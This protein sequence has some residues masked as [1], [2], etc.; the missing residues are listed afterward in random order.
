MQ[1]P[2]GDVDPTERVLWG[3]SSVELLSFFPHFYTV[4]FVTNVFYSN[5]I[6]SAL[7]SAE[8]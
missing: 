3:S 2:A 7:R 4:L 8:I 1:L 5:N 6:R